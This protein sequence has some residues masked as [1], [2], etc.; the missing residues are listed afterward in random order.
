[1]EINL[2]SYTKEVEFSPNTERKILPMLALRINT[3]PLRVLPTWDCCDVLESSFWFWPWNEWLHVCLCVC[4]SEA[5]TENCRLLDIQ[6]AVQTVSCPVITK[7]ASLKE[8]RCS[9]GVSSSPATSHMSIFTVSVP[10]VTICS[11][12][13]NVKTLWIPPH[14]HVFMPSVLFL[15]HSA[16][17]NRNFNGKKLLSV[18][19]KLN[20][21]TGK[22]RALIVVFKELTKG[23]TGVLISS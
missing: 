11:S 19:C 12:E 21:Y 22:Q 15:Q 17:I 23:T 18:M 8:R 16:V 10:V 4:V 7:A 20:L 3:P 2:S 9:S 13:C 1:M 6:S 5:H 14:Q